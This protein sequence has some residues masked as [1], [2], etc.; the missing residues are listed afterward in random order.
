[1]IDFIHNLVMLTECLLL[2]LWERITGR[3]VF[4]F[5]G[6]IDLGDDSTP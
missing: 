4:N 3:K 2:C 5:T 6:S 1:M